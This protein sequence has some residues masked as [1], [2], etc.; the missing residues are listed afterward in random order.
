M[1]E[2]LKILKD[3]YSQSNERTQFWTKSKTIS[4]IDCSR[5]E[6]ALHMLKLASILITA[7]AYIDSNYNFVKLHQ[8][9]AITDDKKC[10]M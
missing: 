6:I 7:F 5:Q 8:C 10:I 9:D 4:I 3:Y 2:N 1:N